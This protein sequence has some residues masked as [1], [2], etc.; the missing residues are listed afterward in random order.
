MTVVVALAFII[1]FLLAYL[2]GYED[3]ADAELE[4]W[5]AADELPDEQLNS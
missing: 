2:V 4:I 1:G 3:G 5:L